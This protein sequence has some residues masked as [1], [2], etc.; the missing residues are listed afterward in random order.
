[1]GLFGLTL[2]L[3]GCCCCCLS[4][5]WGRCPPPCLVVVC[6]SPWR[7]GH[8][9]PYSRPPTYLTGRDTPTL[10]MCLVSFCFPPHHHPASPRLASPC[11]PPPVQGCRVCHP[12]PK[13]TMSAMSAAPP[14]PDRT[15]PVCPTLFASFLPSPRLALP[16]LFLPCLVGLCGLVW[17]CLVGLCGR[18]SPCLCR[19]GSGRWMGGHVLFC[20]LLLLFFLS[21]L[22]VGRSGC[23]HPV[24]S[25]LVLASCYFLNLVICRCRSPSIPIFDPQFPVRPRGYNRG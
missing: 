13:G 19:V 12:P 14:R 4:V 22:S 24:P 25:G 17:P 15:G 20:L 11:H 10:P 5:C 7:A 16:C 8:S 9:R 18:V 2:C 21:V 6:L 23:L 1:M 3:L